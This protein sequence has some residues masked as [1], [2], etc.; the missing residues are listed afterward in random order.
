MRNL[1][2]VGYRT[3]MNIIPLFYVPSRM[4]YNKQSSSLQVSISLWNAVYDT[5]TVHEWKR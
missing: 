3:W 2:F 4:A 1:K 5:K